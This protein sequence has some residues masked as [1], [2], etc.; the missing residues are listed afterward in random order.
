MMAFTM[1]QLTI[2]A[3]FAAAL[4]FLWFWKPTQNPAVNDEK[5]SALLGLVESKM[6]AWE[7]ELGKIRARY[8]IEMQK[9]SQVS[10]EAQQLLAMNRWQADLS[11][12][13]QEEKELK[14]GLHTA[15]SENRARKTDSAIPRLAELEAARARI[16]PEISVDLRSLL[17]DQLA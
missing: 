8:E 12:P 7:E 3:L 14:A 9:L 5:H 1:V 4:L 10:H 17:S 16:Q 2:D 13:T 11:G 15:A 6:I